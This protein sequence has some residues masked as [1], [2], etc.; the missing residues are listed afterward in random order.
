MGG[1]VSASLAEVLTAR[2]L[3]HDVEGKCLVV[4]CDRGKLW[5]LTADTLSKG[6][7]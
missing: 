6:N 4:I 1:Y 5:N 7:I 3:L 2:D